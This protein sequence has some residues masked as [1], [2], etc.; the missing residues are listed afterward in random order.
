M[1]FFRNASIQRKL[2]FVILCTRL[3][4]LRLACLAFEVYERAN[5]RAAMT[6]ELSILADTLGANSAASLAFSDRKSAEETLGALRSD[7]HI[8]AA[9]LY[10]SQ[11]A[12]F[13]EYRR[14]GVGPNH[15]LPSLREDRAQFSSEALRLTRSVY[16][17]GEKAGAIAIISDLTALHAKMTQYTEISLGVLIVS[18]LAAFLVSTRLLRL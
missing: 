4:G 2:T 3:V 17:S 10:D 1:Q 6:S 7:R 14:A 9:C 16:L 12:I 13:A 8:V 11:G 18:T 5:S 15:E